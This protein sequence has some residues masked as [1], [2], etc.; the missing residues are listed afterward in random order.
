MR[1]VW[2]QTAFDF[3]QRP[4]RARKPERLFF[5]LLPDELG[6]FSLRECYERFRIASDLEA[7]PLKP[8]VVLQRLVEDRETV[9]FGAKLAGQA[10][11][12]AG[13]KLAFDTIATTPSRV[14]A[15]T[16][17]DPALAALHGDLDAAIR[18]HG[19]AAASGS[20]FLALAQ[21]VPPIAPEPVKPVK[22]RVTGLA[23]LRGE[24]EAFQVLRRWP[25]NRVSRRLDSAATN[26]NL[27]A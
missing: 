16:S 25:L 15:L 10:V 23:L 7:V 11:A 4:V 18:R 13:L 6:L 1:W 27:P 26:R 12:A 24:V 9:L 19:L 8:V 17:S 20:P 3:C 5:A 2:V 21:G 14:L 22:I